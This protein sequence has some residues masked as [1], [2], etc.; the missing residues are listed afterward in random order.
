ML[1]AMQEEMVVVVV[2]RAI[3]VQFG[4]LMCLG[5]NNVT[6]GDRLRNSTLRKTVYEAKRE[7]LLH[8]LD[9]G[10]CCHRR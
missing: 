5:K 3:R 4:F 8:C 6:C 7:R 9:M 2:G 10:T 1:F